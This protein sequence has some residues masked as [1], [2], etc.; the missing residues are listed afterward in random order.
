MDLTDLPYVHGFWCVRESTLTKDEVDEMQ[1]SCRQGVESLD[2]VARSAGDRF[3]RGSAVDLKSNLGSLSFT[4][5]MEEQEAL[6]EFL[7]Y[8]FYHGALP[9]VADLN[10]YAFGD[11]DETLF[12]DSSLN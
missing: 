7:R 1:R 9:D 3:P 6:T 2:D 4:F 5:A 11:E 8:A 12:S 10:F